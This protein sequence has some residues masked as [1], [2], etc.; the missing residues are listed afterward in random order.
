MVGQMAFRA[1]FF[2]AYAESKKLFAYNPDGSSRE[3]N[4]WD[5]YR[6]RLLFMLGDLCSISFPAWQEHPIAVQQYTIILAFCAVGWSI[7][8]DRGIIRRRTNR[9]LQIAAASA[10]DPAPV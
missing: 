9:L 8:R 10:D 6:V 1:S 3:L 4:G 5:L 7:D 2:A